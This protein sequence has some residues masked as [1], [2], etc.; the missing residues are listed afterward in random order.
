V[1]SVLEAKGLIVV[2]K[3]GKSYR[4][5]LTDLGNDRAHA[6][7]TK[8]SFAELVT[9]MKDIKKTFGSMNGNKIKQLIYEVFDAEVG[10]RARGEVIEG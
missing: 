2:V 8:G 1:L 4:L 5:T 10:Q 7:S 9:R 6:L 3:E